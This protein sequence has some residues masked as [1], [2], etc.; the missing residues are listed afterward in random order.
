MLED[1]MK[2]NVVFQKGC[3]RHIYKNMCKTC[4][5]PININLFYIHKRNNK[6]I[7]CSSNCRDIS[8]LNEIIECSFTNQKYKISYESNKYLCNYKLPDEQN[9]CVDIIIYNMYVKN[10]SEAL[11]KKLTQKIYNRC[12][13]LKNINTPTNKSDLN[14]ESLNCNV[15]FTDNFSIRDWIVVDFETSFLFILLNCNKSSKFYNK[16]AIFITN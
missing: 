11:I 12:C 5:N 2:L 4:S 8:Y 16:I 3:I 1:C 14:E 10:Y 15:V 13:L 6:I 7:Y 9:W